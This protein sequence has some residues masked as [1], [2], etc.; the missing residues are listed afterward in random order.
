MNAV[1]LKMEALM[2]LN[3]S[4]IVQIDSTTAMLKLPPAWECIIDVSSPTYKWVAKSSDGVYDWQNSPVVPDD[5]REQIQTVA[6]KYNEILTD[7]ID[8]EDVRA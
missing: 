8:F 5:I 4:S 3:I 6:S 1:T 2:G 7:L